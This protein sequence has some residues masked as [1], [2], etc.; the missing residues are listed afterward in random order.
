VITTGVGVGVGR[1]VGVGVGRGVGVGVG[2]ARTVGVG[3]G[4]AVGDGL[5]NG[6]GDVLGTGVSVGARPETATV[7]AWG[8]PVGEAATRRPPAGG[9]PSVTARP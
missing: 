7:V 4:V 1:G 2:D 3:L 8:D 5:G 9:F 6:V